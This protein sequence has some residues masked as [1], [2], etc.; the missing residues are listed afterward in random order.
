MA[1]RRVN[2]GMSD[3]EELGLQLT[4]MIDCIFQLLIFFMVNINF[5]S[6]EGLLKAFLPQASIAPSTKEMDKAEIKIAEVEGVLIL[7]WNGQLANGDTEALKYAALETLMRDSQARLGKLPPV[8]IDAQAR[9]AYKYV[10]GALNVCGKLEVKDVM[11][12]IP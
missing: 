5:K 9:L 8:T 7:S 12:A 3:V 1:R 10:V 6:E 11:F 2:E 4:P